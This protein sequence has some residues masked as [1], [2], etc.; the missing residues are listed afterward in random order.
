METSKRFGMNTTEAKMK[1]LFL[2]DIAVGGAATGLLDY[3]NGMGMSGTS[4]LIITSLLSFVISYTR[5]WAT[6][7]GDTLHDL[8]PQIGQV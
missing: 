6:A 1:L 3:V 5:T 4:A 8:P 7:Q 2:L